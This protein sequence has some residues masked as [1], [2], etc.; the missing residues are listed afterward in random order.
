MI[1]CLSL[2]LSGNPEEALAFL[3]DG[4]TEAQSIEIAYSRLHS[5]GRARVKIRFPVFL[6]LTSDSFLLPSNIFI[7]NIVFSMQLVFPDKGC[8]QEGVESILPVN[9]DLWVDFLTS[10]SPV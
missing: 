5:N 7:S 2:P 3:T 6:L 1:L 4:E 10:F 9:P 8:Y